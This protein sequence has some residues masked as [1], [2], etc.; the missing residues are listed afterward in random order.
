MA[1]LS[2][3]S[4]LILGSV[5]GVSGVEIEIEDNLGSAYYNESFLPKPTHF[6]GSDGNETWQEVADNVLCSSGGD[7][8]SVRD[9]LKAL[10]VGEAWF[11]STG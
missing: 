3:I 10:H 8:G 7:A 6:V 11:V 1:K 2:F 9:A 5:F 4:I